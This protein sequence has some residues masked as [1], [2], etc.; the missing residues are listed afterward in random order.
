MANEYA[1][2][3]WFI[4]AADVIVNRAEPLG[5][6]GFGGC[7]ETLPVTIK[8]ITGLV[9]P[10]AVRMAQGEATLWFSLK[11]ANIT[12]LYGVSVDEHGNP[13]FIM[14]RAETSLHSRLY[15][16]NGEKPVSKDVKMRWILQIAQAFKYL[17]SQTN[18]VIHADLNPRKVQIGYDGVAKITDFG[19]SRCLLASDTFSRQSHG[20]MR[21]SPPESFGRGYKA[22]T[23]HD[24]YSFAMTIY[25]ILSEVQPFDDAIHPESIP[26]WVTEGDRPDS[27][28]DQI[29][30]D[31][32]EWSLIQACWDQDP[33]KRPSFEEIIKIIQDQSFSLPQ[34]ISSLSLVSDENG[35]NNLGD[36]YFYGQGVAQDYTKAVEW[37]SLAANEGNAA[38]QFNLGTMYRDGTGVV[39]D[40]SIA[41][42][43][44]TLAANQ[45]DA[46]A[47][48]ALAV[49]YENGQGVAPD[50][51]KAVE[52]Y[53]LAANQGFTFAQTRL[54]FMYENGRG[55]AKN[56]DVAKMWREKA[57]E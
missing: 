46:A 55:I 1:G 3:V 44:F 41:V 32:W 10:K 13:M 53:T 37:Y 19:L 21:Y 34:S 6:G 2:N 49:M 17:H 29:P 43:L 23:A 45:G 42:E 26:K 8:T 24:V 20:A 54:S 50:H 33:T 56:E 5:E 31:S 35:R 40:Y 14:E 9:S 36:M 25:E 12:S 11:H 16:A 18:P 28:P 52:W 39:Q 7:Y 47:Q 15:C 57:E 4:P 30:E 51:A 22:T 38:A 48:F 27:K